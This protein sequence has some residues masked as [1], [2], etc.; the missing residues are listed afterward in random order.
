MR[1]AVAPVLWLFLATGCPHRVQSPTD[2]LEEATAAVSRG[3]ASGHELALAGFKALLSE[4]PPDSATSLFKKSLTL[5]P[6]E[7]YALHGLT[8]LAL[9][10]AHP[11]NALTLALDLCERAP[12]HPLAA[13]SAR[14]ALDLS[15]TATSLDATV[16]A[17]VPG[18]LAKGLPGDAAH[19]LRAALSVAYLDADDLVANQQNLADMGAPTRYAF[20]GP[21]SP[22]HTL[23]MAEPTSPEK[24]GAL[25]DLGQGPFGPLV[26]RT[27]S[28]L[29]GRL[30][31]V[32]EPQAGDVYLAGVDVDVKV[33]GTYVVRTISAMDHVAVLDGTP[34]ITRLTWQRPAPTLSTRAVKLEAGTHRLLIRMA[35]ESQAGYLTV[36]LMHPDG[37]PAGLAFRPAEGKAASWSGVQL[38]DDVPH[39]YPSA[40]AL[41]AA[42]TPDAGDALARVLAARDG[43]GRDRDGARRLLDALP[44]TFTGA[45]LDV[46]KADLELGERTVPSRVARGRATRALEAALGK[47]KGDVRALLLSAQLALD[48]GRQLDALEQLRAAKAQGHSPGGPVLALQARVELA[49]GLD[50]QA[51]LTAKSAAEALPGECDALTLRYDL[52]RRRDDV[53]DAQAHLLAAAHCPSHFSRL[54]EH[55]KTRGHLDAA[56]DAYRHLLA[57]DESQLHAAQSLSNLL[58][59]QRRYDDA[60]KVLQKSQAAWPRSA[61]LKK[62]EAEVLE[63]AGRQGEALAAK[64]A[65]LLLDGGDLALRRAVER[66][67]TGHEL[68]DAWAI[69]T[70]AALKAYQHAPGVETVTSTFLLDAAAIRAYPD[71]SQVDRIH[72]I[73]KA[74]D[75]AGVQDVAEVQIPSGA[76]VLTLRTLKSDGAVLEAES[77]EG[78]DAVSLP[79]VQ[80]GD[81]VEYEFLQAH[82]SRGP[83]QPGF[84]SAA[85]Y[86]QVARQP[87][88]WST[89][90]V[91]APHGMGLA[92]DAHNLTASPVT[93][94]GELDVFTHE[95]KRV[96]PYV[97]EPQ[98]PPSANEWLPFVT[99]GAGQKGNEGVVQA[100]ADAFID[101]GLVTF[102]VEAFARKAAQGKTGLDAVRA[103]YAQVMHALSGRDSGL[104]VSAAASVAQDRGSRTWLLVASLRA[105]GVDARLAAVRAFTVDPKPYL[106]PNESLL[107]YISVRA[108]LQDG[109][110]IWLDPLVR[111]APFGELPEFAM[112]ERDAWLFP[113]P[114]RPLQVVKTPKRSV[115]PSKEVRLTLSL[116]PEGVL[117][118]QGVETYLGYD[119]AQIAEALEAISP[120]QRNQALQSSLS[121]YFG[122][123]DLSS[124]EVESKREVGAPVV[125]KY[126]FTA[127]HF[128]RLDGEA[129][130]VLGALTFPALLGRRFLVMSAR[131]TPLFLEGSE[132]SHTVTT[133]TLPPGW[134]MPGLVADAPLDNPYGHFER[135]EKQVGQT[136]TIDEEHHLVQARVPVKDYETF[137]TFAGEVDLVQGRDVVLEKK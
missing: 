92:V 73:Q 82:P 58:V 113:E 37:R 66:Q 32:G 94:Q 130:M 33:P 123:A 52:A 5:N 17:R 49:L 114:G 118:G 14:I 53:A 109:T 93:T 64:E 61:Q 7:P 42:L 34:L 126:D 6:N 25:D 117:T 122:G 87:N 127:R 125:V 27:L 41:R 47:D 9:R 116:S 96:P 1:R 69:S 11:E 63:L 79:G 110:V 57:L 18:L 36:A 65:A 132:A 108:A 134:T 51:D 60:L 59:A 129:R 38:A 23:A 44:T 88:N 98:G 131:Q 83:G 50:A 45:E 29:D 101:H 71:G 78:K 103:V 95:E 128:A 67:K 99:V 68:L 62:Q 13:P 15:G 21:F 86:F 2:A 3:S 39:L 40:D 56:A 19:L 24:T 111:F 30:A 97:P 84:T 12:A 48:D 81:L 26:P 135:K 137:A 10:S 80:V 119:A 115:R 75:Q 121:R 105:L 85:F 22:W 90:T 106:F 74:L 35:R 107:P 76:A 89:Y 43:L 91:V 102:E 16:R 54:G 46:L 124:L 112:G 28:V 77:I 72:V 133:L 120:D 31:L 136:V 55:E 20:V 104:S 100:Y 8:L 4:G 70:D